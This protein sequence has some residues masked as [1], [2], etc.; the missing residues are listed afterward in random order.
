MAADIWRIKYW[1][2][3]GSYQS[4]KRDTLSLY[5]FVSIHKP[6]VVHRW[7]EVSPR[8][9]VAHLYAWLHTLSVC[10][11]RCRSLNRLQDGRLMAKQT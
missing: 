5:V 9:S 2:M 7:A 4:A 6:F 10:C 8:E 11:F 1:G 3:L